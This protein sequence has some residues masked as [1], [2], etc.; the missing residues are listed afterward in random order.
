MESKPGK[1]QDKKR[2]NST[3]LTSE[4]KLKVNELLRVSR[5][6]SHWKIEKST[7]TSGHGCQE[8]WWNLNWSSG[9]RRGTERKQRRGES[10]WCW[11][12]KREDR[13]MGILNLNK[14]PLSTEWINYDNRNTR[15][16]WKVLIRAKVIY[17]SSIYRD[18]EIFFFSPKP[19]I[20]SCKPNCLDE[21]SC[22]WPLLTMQHKD[23][24]ILDIV[25]SY[26]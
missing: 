3:A 10:V 1:G 13:E 17:L 14:F 15:L 19:V 26:I 24:A 11:A 16:E 23:T 18:T 4:K 12:W 20:K 8:G 22:E 9:V 7:S 2:R 25:S 5:N 6:K 21:T